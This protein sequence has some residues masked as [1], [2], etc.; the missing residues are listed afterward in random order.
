[1]RNVVLLGVYG[2]VVDEDGVGRILSQLYLLY[3]LGMLMR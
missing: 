2:G 1:M 3:W